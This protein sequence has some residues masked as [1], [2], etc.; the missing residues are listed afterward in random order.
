MVSMVSAPLETVFKRSFGDFH[1]SVE[2][3]THGALFLTKDRPNNKI[4]EKY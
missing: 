4:H 3:K 1:L 2:R